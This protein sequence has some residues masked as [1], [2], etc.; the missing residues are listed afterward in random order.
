MK[1]QKIDCAN[2][3]VS[4][5]PPIDRPQRAERH[6]IDFA[7]RQRQRFDSVGNRQST[8]CVADDLH[9][10]THSISRRCKCPGRKN[11]ERPL[12]KPQMA[13]S[14]EEQPA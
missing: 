4:P 5:F 14:A 3:V 2:R 8:L 10:Q 11:R 6:P 9:D 13:R 12:K 1:D 7:D